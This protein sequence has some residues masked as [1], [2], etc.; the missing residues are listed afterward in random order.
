MERYL[1]IGIWPKIDEIL[2]T[3]MG[4]YYNRYMSLPT[5]PQIP[6]SGAPFANTEI[7]KSMFTN[8]AKDIGENIANKLAKCCR[9]V[10]IDVL[11][12]TCNGLLEKLRPGQPVCFVRNK[13]RIDYTKKYPETG[14]AFLEQLT[15]YIA[16]MREMETEFYYIN[17]NEGY[18]FPKPEEVY[19]AY[20]DDAVYT[21]TQ[22]SRICAEYPGIQVHVGAASIPGILA[23]NVSGRVPFDRIHVTN[24]MLHLGEV[25]TQEELETVRRY[26]REKNPSEFDMYTPKIMSGFNMRSVF[27]ELTNT[28]V[29]ANLTSV[30][31]MYLTLNVVKVPDYVSYPHFGPL[32][33][34]LDFSTKHGH[35]SRFYIPPVGLLELD[36]D[37]TQSPEKRK[38]LKEL[39]QGVPGKVKHIKHLKVS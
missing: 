14:Q 28:E 7:Y 30:A 9:W 21:G 31:L 13:P 33:E 19:L 5:L 1:G 26:L 22:S 27:P 17:H 23:V 11:M 38:R 35:I 8:I 2:R 20:L 24:K 36:K 16:G 10:T 37:L 29:G 15:V 39:E 3:R 12:E 25:F 34:L 18:P 32:G 4:V 6:A